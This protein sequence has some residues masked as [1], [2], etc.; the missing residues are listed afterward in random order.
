MR[1]FLLTTA[2]LALLTAGTAQAVPSNIEAG[3]L[4]LVNGARSDVGQLPLQWN[5]GTPNATLP[6]GLGAASQAH[7]DDEAAHG[8]NCDAHNSCDGTYWATRVIRY[9]T[10]SI[11]LGENAAVSI[12]DPFQLHEGW[13]E[14]SAHR[15]NI[16]TSIFTEF[17]TG[18]AKAN[19]FTFA[20][21]DF[22]S[23]GQLPVSTYPPLQAGFIWPLTGGLEE[24]QV[25]ASFFD[26]N[27]PPISVRAVTDTACVQLPLMQ[28]AGDMGVYGRP[29]PFPPSGCTPVVFEAVRRTGER[30]RWPET[31]AIVVASGGQVCPERTPQ[32][33]IRDCGSV[34]T[35]LPSRTSGPTPTGVEPTPEPTP[36]PG[37]RPTKQPTPTPRP[38]PTRTPTPT[39]KPRQTKQPTPTPKPK[40]TRTPKG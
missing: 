14:S 38:R 30:Y 29:Y 12:S 23:R 20:T 6:G 16:L 31:E 19:T 40:P 34:A 11:Y 8:F 7:S 2:V 21:E 15:A 1:R 26:Q 37:P 35:P 4:V 9:Y 32:P 13:M 3:L 22:G 27:S 28:G 10:G 36:T 24:R 39:P 18:L 25:Q 33:Q 5:D 17:G